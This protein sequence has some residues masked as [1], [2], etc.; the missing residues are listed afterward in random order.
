MKMT[1][2]FMFYHSYKNTAL[3]TVI[4]AS[5]ITKQ[6][7]CF[8]TYFSILFSI[9]PAVVWRNQ[10]NLCICR[11][12]SVLAVYNQHGSQTAKPQGPLITEAHL[13]D[14]TDLT[15]HWS[16]TDFYPYSTSGLRHVIEQSYTC[17]LSL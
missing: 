8:G 9:N 17:P 12:C 16:I 15:D 10:A 11:V 6:K 1:T 14:K 13:L 5:K 2:S 3:M 7:N 4:T